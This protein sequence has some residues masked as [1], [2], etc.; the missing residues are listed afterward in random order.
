MRERILAGTTARV[1]VSTWRKLLRGYPFASLISLPVP[2]RALVAFYLGVQ[3]LSHV[4][5]DEGRIDHP[6]SQ[7]NRLAR[8]LHR[9]PRL[10]LR[11][12]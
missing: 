10:Y 9:V 2:A 6:F 12:T 5:G 4:D 1:T 8:V 3:T 7:A 11:Q